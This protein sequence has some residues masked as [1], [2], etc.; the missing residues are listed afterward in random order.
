MKRWDSENLDE[1]YISRRHSSDPLGLEKTQ[2]DT[3]KNDYEN[4][5]DQ[6]VNKNRSVIGSAH[7]NQILDSAQF[8][9]KA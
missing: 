1:R 5:S 8:K 4:H 2:K 7:G 3:S 6:F 9:Y